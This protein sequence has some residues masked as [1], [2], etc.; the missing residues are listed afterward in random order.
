MSAPVILLASASPRRAK[1]LHLLGISFQTV[2]PDV[3]EIA[4]TGGTS[5]PAMVAI[6]NARIKARSVQSEPGQLILAADTIVVLGD[7]LF[8]KPEDDSDARRILTMLSGQTHSVITGICLRAKDKER[9]DS[10]ESRV[11][12]RQLD[13]ATIDAYIHTGEPQDKAGAYAV[14]GQG[15]SL[16]ETVEGDYY[17]VVGL[18]LHRLSQILEEFG[19]LTTDYW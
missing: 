17:N 1:L 10:A 7:T 8:G 12:F 15:A 19:I 18:P 16:V 9:V 14:Q 6:E 3:N 5:S 11:T 2:R 13:D 4:S